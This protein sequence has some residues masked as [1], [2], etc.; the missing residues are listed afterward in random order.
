ME[1]IKLTIKKNLV[2]KSRVNQ[3]DWENI[4]FG[5]VFTD[6]ML[7][8]NF[9]DGEWQTPELVPFANLDFHPALLSLHYGQSIFEGMK[10]YRTNSG[11]VALFRPDLNAKRFKHSATRMDMPAIPE[12][13]FEFCLKE[14]IATDREWVPK[15]EG[16]SLYIRPFMFATDAYIG[17][18]TSETYRFMIIAS[19]A[20]SGG[21]YYSDSLRVKIEE[22]YTR[23]A[24]GGVGSVKAAGNYG[25]SLFAERQARKE[26]YNQIIWT[27]AKNHEFVEEAGTMN[28]LFVKDGVL[29]T[30][31]EDSDT[32]LQ[33]T[34]KRSV[35]DLAKSW[36]VKVE[37]RKITVKE[38]IEGLE[39]G[40]ITEAFGAGTAATIAAIS[41]IGY[42]GTHYQL[43]EE[44]QEFTNRALKELNG[45]KFGRIKDEFNWL[46][47]V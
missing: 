18:K 42:R 24:E 26:G 19:P 32:I 38:V 41:E 9:T 4:K 45:I 28:L 46:V 37:E 6:H 29:I 23:A 44:N 3:I 33:G 22:K 20:V 8:M 25:A 15:A 47:K 2:E 16:D 34:T 10:A 36:G 14:F 1:T 13:L 30:P 21:V 17:I 27:D 43:K 39:S 31:S 7:V 12:E 35:I 5:R 40:A 11:E